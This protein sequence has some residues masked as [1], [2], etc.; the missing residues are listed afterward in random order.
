MTRFK[1]DQLYPTTAPELEVI[2]TRGTLAV[3]RHQGKGPGYIRFGNKVLYEGRALNAW[4]DEHRVE[5][6]AA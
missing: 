1:D 5:P 6:A 2:A 3:W 4:L